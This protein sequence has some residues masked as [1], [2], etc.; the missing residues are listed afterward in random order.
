MLSEHKKLFQ[1]SIFLTEIFNTSDI[2][3]SDKSQRLSAYSNKHQKWAEIFI[4]A[5]FTTLVFQGLISIYLKNSS[6]DKNFYFLAIIGLGAFLGYF[7]VCQNQSSSICVYINSLLTFPNLFSKFYPTTPVQSQKLNQIDR[8]NI[9]TAYGIIASWLLFPLA[10]VFGLHFNDPCKISFI[11]Y[12]LIPNC[13]T[14][15]P[16]HAILQIFGSIF[17]YLLNFLTWS[18]SFTSAPLTASVLMILCS[19]TIRKNLNM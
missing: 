19:L 18:V 9:L 8:T 3:W 7:K 2:K 12:W 13:S 10:F 17:I 4:S 5:C 11:G 16:A 1:L 15:I 14:K 6:D